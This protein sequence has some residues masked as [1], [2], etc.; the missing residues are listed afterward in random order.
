MEILGQ[1][2]MSKQCR[3]RSKQ[4]DQGLTVCHS[5]STFRYVKGQQTDLVKLYVNYGAKSKIYPVIMVKF[6]IKKSKKKKKKLLPTLPILYLTR[7]EGSARGVG[8]GEGAYRISSHL[9]V[10]VGV[11]FSNDIS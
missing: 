3:S 1:V 10:D 8:G 2:G 9:I 5:I 7:A 4:I 11:T 6:Y